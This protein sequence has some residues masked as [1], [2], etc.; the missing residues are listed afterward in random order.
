[1]ERV[2]HWTLDVVRLE[3]VRGPVIVQSAVAVEAP[4]VDWR[5]IIPRD[6]FLDLMRASD[7]LV[8]HGGLGTIME[9][10]GVGC[11]PI[12]VPREHRYGEHVDDHQ[13]YF[14]KVLAEYG[15]G[16]VRTI[17]EFRAAVRRPHDPNAAPRIL[18]EVSTGMRP[19]EELLSNVRQAM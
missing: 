18:R 11:T 14:S 12:V 5:P 3:L 6:E 1:M 16:I 13:V 8:T 19:L 7:V 4:G 9:A 10:F 15:I 17:E 2:V